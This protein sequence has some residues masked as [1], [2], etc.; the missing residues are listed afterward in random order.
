MEPNVNIG[1]FTNLVEG[2]TRIVGCNI[3]S[4]TYSR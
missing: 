1:E 4:W 2:D 3:E